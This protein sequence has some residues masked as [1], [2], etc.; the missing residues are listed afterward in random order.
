MPFFIHLKLEIALAISASKEFKILTDK[1]VYLPLCE[2]AN[3][4]FHI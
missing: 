3:T 2:V 4:P 1:R